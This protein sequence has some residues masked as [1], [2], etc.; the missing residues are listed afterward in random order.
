MST[1]KVCAHA[2]FLWVM[3]SSQQA[4]EGR[5][6]PGRASKICYSYSHLFHRSDMFQLRHFNEPISHLDESRRMNDLRS[7]KCAP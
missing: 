3:N 7:E 2:I 6:V 4:I 1:P 5:E